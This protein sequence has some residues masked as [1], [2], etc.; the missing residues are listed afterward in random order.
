MRLNEGL[1]RKARTSIV[2]LVWAVSL[3]AAEAPPAGLHNF[4]QVDEHVYRGGQPSEMGVKSLAK[5]GIKA[6]I[7]L[8]GGGERSVAEQKEVEAHGMKYY[9]IPMPA[10]NAPS[11]AEISTALALI[12]DS[13]NWPVYIHCL[14]GKDRTGTVIACYRI[15]HDRWPNARAMKEAQAHGLSRVERGMRT[16]VLHYNPNVQNSILAQSSK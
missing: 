2:L 7:D 3:A 4:M 11:D 6:V 14:R 5:L 9:S 10:F 15:R 16:Y 12:N 1:A 13:Q 8:R